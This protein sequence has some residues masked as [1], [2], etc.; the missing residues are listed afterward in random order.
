[1]N[2]ILS[3]QSQLVVKPSSIKSKVLSLFQQWKGVAGLNHYH[4]A[5]MVEQ[6]M[7]VAKRIYDNEYRNDQRGD[8]GSIDQ[9]IVC[10]NI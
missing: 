3:L 8:P 4:R 2:D 6:N 10:H 9:V 7:K 1:M 5:A